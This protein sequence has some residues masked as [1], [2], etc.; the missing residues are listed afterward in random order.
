MR[1]AEAPH[2]IAQPT[3]KG[4]PRYPGDWM[5]AA[6]GRYTESLS[7]VIELAPRQAR[8]RAKLTAAITS[9]VPAQRTIRLGRRSCIA[10]QIVLHAS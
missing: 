8:L 3:T 7:F 2:E 1:Q 5:K 6:G 4:Q 9:A 10:F